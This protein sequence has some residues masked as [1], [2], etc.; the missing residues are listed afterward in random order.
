MHEFSIACSL[1]E[2]LLQ[3][4]AENPDKKIVEVRLEV[5]E[6]SHIEEE[7]LR[8]SYSSI[9]AE[10]P[11][12]GSVLQIEHVEAAVECSYC[13]YRGRPKYWHDALSEGPVATLQCPQ[14]GKAASAV[15]GQE[16][17]IKSVKFLQ[18]EPAVL[19]DDS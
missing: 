15:A 3:F 9:T 13:H 18:S 5:G 16:C 6:L 7:Q 11:L 12:E 1:V 14:C 19:N 17:A 2:K 4:A 8:F 10:T